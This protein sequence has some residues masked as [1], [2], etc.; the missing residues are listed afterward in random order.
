MV[1]LTD[2][3]LAAASFGPALLLMFLTLREYTFPRVEKPF[4]DDS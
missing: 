4:F 3:L 1:E 2:I